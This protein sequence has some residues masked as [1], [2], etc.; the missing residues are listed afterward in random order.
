MCFCFCCGAYI[1]LEYF[2]VSVRL[3]K[4]KSA[5]VKRLA[6]YVG[7]FA[8]VEQ[9]LFRELTE[10]LSCTFVEKRE[11]IVCLCVFV[12]VREVFDIYTTVNC[13]HSWRPFS[14]CANRHQAK[15]QIWQRSIHTFEL[16][17]NRET[18]D[19]RNG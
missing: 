5:C 14:Q 13:N 2:V 18:A 11:R 3:S 6:G 19:T 17:E 1:R 10:R 12:C 15:G 9:G 16:L 4:G 8:K 7:A